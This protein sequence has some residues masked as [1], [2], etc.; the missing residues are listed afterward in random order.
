MG[1]ANLNT[2]KEGRDSS[3]IGGEGREEACDDG[4]RGD[5]SL[6]CE[7]QCDGSIRRVSERSPPAFRRKG[8][9]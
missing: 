8:L 7:C 5:G 4:S 6:R 1:E 2:A 9:H 3:A